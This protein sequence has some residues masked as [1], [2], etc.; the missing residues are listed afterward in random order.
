MGWIAIVA[1][2]VVV[3]LILKLARPDAVFVIELQD[4]TAK[5]SHGVVV[6]GFLSL[7]EETAKEF[8][9]TRGEIRGIARQDEIALWFSKD[10]PQPFRQRLRNAWVMSGWKHRQ[11][12]R[13]EDGPR[14][15]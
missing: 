3:L 14:Y 2:V 4:G 12:H 9:I 1:V 8:M 15:G 6:Q 7:V 5:A 13:Y 11:K 10:L